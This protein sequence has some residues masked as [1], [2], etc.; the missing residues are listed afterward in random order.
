MCEVYV[1]LSAL[2]WEVLMSVLECWN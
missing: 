2:P 1:A